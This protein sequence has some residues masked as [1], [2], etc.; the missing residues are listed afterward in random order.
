MSSHFLDISAAL[1]TNLNTFATDNSIPVAWENIDY[2]PIAGTL[3]LRSTILPA[4]TLP[5]GL[6]NTSS[7]DHLGLYQ[8]DVISPIDK[9]KGQAF[10]KA[11]LL[12]THFARGELTYNGVIIRIKSVSRGSG[13]RDNAWFV[14]PVFI[15]YQSII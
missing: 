8:I 4:D 11:D 3:F 14:V 15:N 2:Q 13:S 7:E 12:A 9:G 6:G 5:I 1:D 10:T